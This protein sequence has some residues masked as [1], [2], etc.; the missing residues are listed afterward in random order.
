MGEL[1]LLTYLVLVCLVL[2]TNPVMAQQAADETPEKPSLR[3]LCTDSEDGALDL[4]AFL[5]TT[6]GFLPMGGLITEPAVGFGVTL[7]LVFLHDS[8]ENRVVEAKKRNSDG[9]KV[10]LPPPSVSGIFGMGTENMT[11]GVGAFH[12]GFWKDDRIRY[13]GALG[14][15]NANLDYYFD[16][17][18]LPIDHVSYNLKG[19]GLLQEL[20]FRLMQTNFFLGANYQYMSFKTKFD[21]GISLPPEI[22]PLEKTIEAG[23]VGVVVGYDTR[24]SVFT[25]DSGVDAN[26]EMIFYDEVFGSERS[27]NKVNTYLHGWIPLHPS[28]ILGLRADGRFSE[29]G[30]PFYMLPNIALRGIPAT[31]Y[32]GKHA[33]ATETE[34]RWDITERWS[35]LGFA[36]AGWVAEREFNE[37]SFSDA[38]FAGGTGFRY[39]ISGVFDIRTGMDFAWSEDDFA[40]YFTTGTAW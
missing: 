31:R 13:M 6:H 26:F 20:K 5:A 14:Y 29:D 39:L 22:P 8:I 4:S 27:F 38:H 34:L 21:L 37:Y 15:M 33:L 18:L 24:N 10:R 35:L 23:G 36:G 40:F 12:L 7:G 30:T 1:K 2:V 16:R 25:P 11:K 19:P 28:W 17:P 9:T 3:D 32:Q